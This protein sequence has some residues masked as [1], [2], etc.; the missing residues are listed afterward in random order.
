MKIKQMMNENLPDV[1]SQK[2]LTYRPT[3][4][5][6]R[7]MYR[8]LNYEIF[9]NKLPMPWIEIS[10]R[11]RGYWGLCTGGYG[12]DKSNVTIRL[13]NKFYCRQ[14][15]IMVLAHEMCHQYQWDI[16]SKKRA[17]EG[18]EPLMSHGPSFFKYK[19]KLLRHGIPLKRAISTKVW[20]NK[21]NLLKC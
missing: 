13:M 7:K 8:Q 16:I 6:V 14:W 21:Q 3:I 18:K 9:N 5:E 1:T 19:K 2:K 11:C 10:A 17:K 12:N 15:F 4:R 20:F